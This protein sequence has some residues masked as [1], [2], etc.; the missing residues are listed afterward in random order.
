MAFGFFRRRQKLVI[1]I[2]AVLMVSFLVSY[3]GFMSFTQR[4]AAKMAIGTTKMG[5]VTVGQLDTAR[6]ELHVLVNY[7]GIGNPYRALPLDVEMIALLDHRAEGERSMAFALLLREAKAAGYKTFDQEAE[8]FLTQIGL[9]KGSEGRRL[10]VA[11][12]RSR[13]AGNEA[14]LVSAVRDWMT[15]HKHFVASSTEAPPSAGVLTHLFRD[16]TE[17]I[18]LRYAIVDAT[19]LVDQAPEPAEEEIAAQFDKDKASVAGKFTED[20]PYG[21][22][23][24][25]PDRVNVQ[26]LFVPG[27]VLGRAVVPTDDELSEYYLAHTDEFVS[28]PSTR[29]ASSQ[30]VQLKFS[31]VRGQIIEKLRRNSENARMD[32]VLGRAERLL[33]EQAAS[34]TPGPDPY[35]WV[36]DRMTRSVDDLLAVRVGAVDIRNERL[37]EAVKRLAAAADVKAIVYPYGGHGVS[38]LEP[39]VRVTVRGTDVTLADALGQ[40]NEQVKIES[41]SWVGFEMFNGVLFPAD[42]SGLQPLIVGDSGMI[43]RGESVDDTILS[44]AYTVSGEPLLDMAFSVEGLTKD[45]SS[46]SLITLGAEAPRME[47]VD[48]DNPGKLL[49]RV[50]EAK[51]SYVPEELTDELREQVVKDLKTVAAMELAVAKADELLSAARES[52]LEVAGKDAGVDTETTDLFARKQ[53]ASPRQSLAMQVRYGLIEEQNAVWEQYLY[54]P[55]AF[56]WSNVPGLQ[57]PTNDLKR[58]FMETAFGLAPADVEPAEG[59]PPY[60][61]KSYALAKLEIPATREVMV[62]QR[63]GYRP[64]VEPTFRKGVTDL[65]R[66]LVAID[67][68]QVQ[69]AWFD[70]DSI[71]SRVDWKPEERS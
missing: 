43:G 14:I 59:W 25:Q 37:D 8:G 57:L 26:Y 42:D 12:M 2:M 51:A 16:M 62:F 64:V 50:T 44:S 32:E 63:E 7:V 18:S 33:D 22:G 20:N 38:K 9:A 19:D 71:V 67:Q 40:I 61:E 6:A 41:L 15:I 68:W 56:S 39:S 70:Y 48:P 60:P 45:E 31:Q 3:Q 24:K 5:K 4:N 27:E 10:Q 29:S 65:G 58:K 46:S 11:Q 66:T 17:Q 49:W 30:P 36:K 53:A 1:V 47:V 69:D 34:G 55:L 52:G 13:R 54:P 35:E 23:Y 21:F 28:E